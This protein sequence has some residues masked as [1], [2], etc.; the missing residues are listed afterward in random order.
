VLKL[1]SD[2]SARGVSVVLITHRLQDLFEVADR[3]VVLY[4]GVNHKEMPP[5]DTNLEDL[6]TAMMGK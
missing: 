2:V 4:E 5:S 1:I 3:F 6:V